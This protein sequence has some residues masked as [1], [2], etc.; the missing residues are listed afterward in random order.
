MGRNT[1]IYIGLFR[2]RQ[3][4]KPTIK[5]VMDTTLDSDTVKSL[6]FIMSDLIELAKEYNA[7]SVVA[8]MEKDR[9]APTERGHTTIASSLQFSNEK[10][11]DDFRQEVKEL[12]NF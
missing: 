3:E 12:L 2:D 7:H 9:Y 6:L 1:P 4:I 5:I 8:H 11:F 10:N